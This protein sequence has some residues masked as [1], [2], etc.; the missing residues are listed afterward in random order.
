MIAGER[1][2]YLFILLGLL[3]VVALGIG[4]GWF[5]RVYTTATRVASAYRIDLRMFL[6]LVGVGS[7]TYWLGSFLIV[8]EAGTSFV[9]RSI[10]IIFRSLKNR[11]SWQVGWE[12][13]SQ[14]NPTERRRY[15]RRTI[16]RGGSRLIKLIEN[17]GV[18]T[19]LILSRGGAALP[20]IYVE[21]R[22]YHPPWFVHLPTSFLGITVIGWLVIVMWLSWAR[23]RG[24]M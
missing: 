20:W 19:G 10:E 18:M 8:Q 24:L 12:A 9:R 21:I 4:T 11:A 14:R 6:I 5:E 3:T 23:A 22:A 13:W 2:K 1:K 16:Q 15:L 17:R 7:A